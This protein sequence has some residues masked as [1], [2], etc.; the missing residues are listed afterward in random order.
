M[1]A[2]AAP[3][4]TQKSRAGEPARLRALNVSHQECAAVSARPYRAVA[5]RLTPRYLFLCFEINVTL[6]L[7][8]AV[9]IA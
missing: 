5:S 8:R 7:A 6:S 3:Q 9:S 2:S 1:P 4:L